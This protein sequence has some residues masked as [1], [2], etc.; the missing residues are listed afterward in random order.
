MRQRDLSR[1]IASLSTEQAEISA[2]VA[3]LAQEVARLKLHIKLTA[4]IADAS[5]TEQAAEALGAAAS[6]AL[7]GKGLESK[8]E[9]EFCGETKVCDAQESPNVPTSAM[10]SFSVA[11]V[12]PTRAEVDSEDTI[13]SGESE[14]AAGILNL[15]DRLG[16]FIKP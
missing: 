10:D 3:R 8:H 9:P 1:T 7:E 15:H 16:S 6:C 5:K 13:G 14:I 4:A 11:R 12:G 2:A